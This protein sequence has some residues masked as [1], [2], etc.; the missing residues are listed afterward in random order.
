[1]NDTIVNLAIVR[2]QR[3][4]FEETHREQAHDIPIKPYRHRLTGSLSAS[5]PYRGNRVKS[6]QHRA[7]SIFWKKR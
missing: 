7:L 2:L 3:V 1:M 4:E 6:R 5:G